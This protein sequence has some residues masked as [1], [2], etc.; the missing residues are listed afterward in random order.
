MIATKTINLEKR[1]QAAAMKEKE[2]QAEL[3]EKGKMKEKLTP[4]I[5]KLSK[6]LNMLPPKQLN[7]PPGDR[8]KREINMLPYG[9]LAQECIVSVL[10]CHQKM[11]ARKQEEWTRLS[12]VLENINQLL[13]GKAAFP[14]K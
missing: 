7:M 1:L 3:N 12:Q 2:K 14:G 11:L 10:D 4:E 13:R 6:Q 9:A 5:E 8:Q